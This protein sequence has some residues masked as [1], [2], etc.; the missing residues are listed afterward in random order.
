M[1]KNL[2]RLERWFPPRQVYLKGRGDIRYFTLSPTLQKS[3]AASLIV[4]AG[5]VGYSSFYTVF[6]DEIIQ[7]K[8]VEIAAIKSESAEKSKDL[9]VL[10]GTILDKTD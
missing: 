9:E 6:Q 4:V 8:D 3:L 5:W 2:S 10:G 7:G 1:D